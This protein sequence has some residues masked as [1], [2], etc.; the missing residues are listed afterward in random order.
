[1]SDV[2]VSVEIEA[3]PETVWAVLADVGLVE[4]WLTVHEDFEDP[5]TRIRE[6][7]ELQQRVS[8]GDISADVEWLIEEIDEPVFMAWRGRATGGA[9]LRTTYRLVATDAGTRVECA[10]DFDLPGGPLG[11]VAA[12]VAAPRGRE[13]AAASLDRLRRLVES[14]EA[15]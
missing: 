1:M 12:K 4:D 5:P 15:A 6:G 2:D 3:V 10:T 11:S 7:A 8:S 9:E 13:E 14:R